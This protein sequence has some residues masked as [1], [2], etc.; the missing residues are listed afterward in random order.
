MPKSNFTDAV[1]TYS[2]SIFKS[3]PDMHSPSS[4]FDATVSATVVNNDEDG[5]ATL[6]A[7]KS[8]LSRLLGAADSHHRFALARLAGQPGERDA[9]APAQL[10]GPRHQQDHARG[11]DG[12]EIESI[13]GSRLRDQRDVDLALPELVQQ[14][15]AR[16]LDQPHLQARSLTNQSGHGLGCMSSQSLA[17]LKDEG[18]QVRA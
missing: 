6:A 14:S 18:R 5:D 13:G 7:I 3:D 17:S 12:P 4:A 16:S 1:D 10:A 8:T 9:P 2:L 11:D 15:R